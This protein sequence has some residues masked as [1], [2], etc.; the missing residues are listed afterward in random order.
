MLGNKGNKKDYRAGGTRGGQDQFKWED[1]KT[2]KYR[3]YYLGNSVNA[4]A[5]RWQKGKD[6]LWYTKSKGEQDRA[7]EEERER[8]RQADDDIIN[9]K[10]GLPGATRKRKAD[11]EP[12]A[13]GPALD[14][15][16]MRQLVGRGAGTGA[17][18]G[19]GDHGRGESQ[20]VAG[21]GAAP[22]RWHE[23]IERP[24]LSAGAAMGD[25]S[26]H[27][28]SSS[29]PS[30]GNSSSNA[31]NAGQRPSDGGGHRP[32]DPEDDDA[33]R[34]SKKEKREKKEKKEKK[35]K[36]EKKEKKEKKD[37]HERWERD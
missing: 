12:S 6:I 25:G 14:A 20:R 11:D 13:Y 17:G 36:R 7:L 18:D 4:P 26:G 29:I 30:S 37:K 24:S 1:V 28:G 21:L 19:N 16:E 15:G 33:H 9:E 35:E 27:G 8:I 34:H 31:V 5:G 22:A 32:R 23:H 3:E 2:D 10:L